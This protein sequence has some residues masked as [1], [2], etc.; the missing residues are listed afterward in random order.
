MKSSLRDIALARQDGVEGLVGLGKDAKNVARLADE[1][2]QTPRL[3][4]RALE[5][6]WTT[7]GH[8]MPPGRKVRTSWIWS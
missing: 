2:R 1:E 8:R 3:Q 5:A 4:L 7:R 6:A